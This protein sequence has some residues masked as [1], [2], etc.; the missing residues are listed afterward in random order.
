MTV[1]PGVHVL[2]DGPYGRISIP[3]DRFESLV[4]VA[5]GIGITPIASVLG[6][7]ASAKDLGRFKRLAK[8]KLVWAAK[9]AGEIDVFDT[10][11]RRVQGLDASLGGDGGMQ[12]TMDLF[13]TREPCAAEGGEVPPGAY[14]VQFGRRPDVGDLVRGAV[15][16]DAPTTAVLACGPVH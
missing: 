8:L 11:L 7:I 15:G 5:G 6:Y 4:L 2:L 9:Y 14:Q 10:L 3:L 12:V 16:E 1:L 13:A